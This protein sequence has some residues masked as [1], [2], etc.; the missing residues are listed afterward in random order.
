MGYDRLGWFSSL[1]WYQSRFHHE[2]V[3]YVLFNDAFFIINLLHINKKI[4]L[5]TP[6]ESAEQFLLLLLHLQSHFI[7]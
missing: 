7:F 4:F 3:F 2:F 1:L 6:T 5:V